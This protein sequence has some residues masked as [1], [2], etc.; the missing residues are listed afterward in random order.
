MSRLDLFFLGKMFSDFLKLVPPWK[1]GRFKSCTRKKQYLKVLGYDRDDDSCK[2]RM[3]TVITAYRNYSD[4]KRNSTGAA[5]PKMPP[6]CEEIDNIMGD[7]P[8]TLPPHLISSS[9]SGGGLNVVDH[10]KDTKTNHK[11]VTILF[12]VKI[13]RW[14]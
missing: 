14:L 12:V 13:Y 5:P 10:N 3:H 8:T 9:G 7:K 6:Y 2:V 1:E 11:A 4:V